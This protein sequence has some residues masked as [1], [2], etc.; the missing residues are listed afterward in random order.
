MPSESTQSH[1]LK[2]LIESLLFV[3]EKPV[4]VLEIAKVTAQPE[5]V[6]V[7]SLENLIREYEAP[8]GG[9]RI[10]NVAGGYQLCTAPE[11]AEW[12]K[13]FCRYRFSQRLSTASLEALAIIA[14]KQ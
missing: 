5:K 1:N 14:Y 8:G 10:L 2:A 7:D 12:I 4:T 13:K 11:H 9:L 6:I 3:S